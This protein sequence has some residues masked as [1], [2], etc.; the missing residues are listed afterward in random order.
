MA[1]TMVREPAV[2][3]MFYPGAA[4]SLER[5]VARHLREDTVHH[6]LLGCIA[7]HAG[8]VYSG[9]VAG[10][11]YGHLRIPRRVVVLGPNHTGLGAP[12]AVAPHASWRTP[13]GP[14]PLDRELARILLEEFPAARPDELAHGREHSLEVQL[15]FIQVRR[16]DAVV[17]PVVLQHLGLE[18]CLELGAALA[19]AIRR[20]GEP[21]GIVASS[22][23]SHYEPDPVARERDRL[24]IEAALTLDPAAL[25][26]TVHA[27]RISM[28]GVVP[29]TVML[30]AVGELGVTGGHLVDYATSGDTGGDRSSVVGY[31]GVCFYDGA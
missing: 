1:G 12:V 22:D 28:C 26:R 7:P 21:V 23:M 30:A 24:A 14:E 31:A 16:P 15:P 8:Y 9:P 18:E 19:R 4:R 10:K 5:E 27:D 17:L 2:A 6:D 20:T 11:L 13:L 3:G 29:A 25:Y